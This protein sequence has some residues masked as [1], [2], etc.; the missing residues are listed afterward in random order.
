MDKVHKPSDSESYTSSEPFKEIFTRSHFSPSNQTKE[1]PWPESA[2]DRRLL[3]ELVPTF[4]ERGC[5]V[6]G[7]MDPYGRILGFLDR[8]HLTNRI[9]LEE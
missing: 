1:T 2:S 3:A 9:K 4:A 5:H 7:L 6:V 8:L